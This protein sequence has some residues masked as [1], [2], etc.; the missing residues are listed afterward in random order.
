M[1]LC[2]CDTDRGK[3]D[4]VAGEDTGVLAM[5]GAW[6]KAWKQEETEKRPWGDKLTFDPFS[7]SGQFPRSICSNSDVSQRLDVCPSLSV[8][9]S[10]IES[11]HES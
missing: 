8:S 9:A 10:V 2:V 4:L 6:E 3:S 11:R 5:V 1:L 7:S